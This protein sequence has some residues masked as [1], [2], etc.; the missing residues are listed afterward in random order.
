MAS[1]PVYTVTNI[2][3]SVYRIASYLYSLNMVSLTPT[4]N[5]LL[6]TFIPT[7]KNLKRCLHVYFRF[8]A[9]CTR[10]TSLTL[11]LKQ[12][13]F[14]RSS[15]YKSTIE[16]NFYCFFHSSLRVIF[17]HVRVP[18]F[19]RPNVQVHQISCSLQIHV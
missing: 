15:S 2:Y 14:T 4:L 6:C 10:Y 18:S 8:C 5:L 17:S 11:L 16:T 13:R 9:R 3:R 12:E 7:S 1:L 19:R